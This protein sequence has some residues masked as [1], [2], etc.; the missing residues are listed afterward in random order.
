LSSDNRPIT[1]A[2]AVTRP[3]RT[4]AAPTSHGRTNAAN[5]TGSVFG[6]CSTVV[7]TAVMGFRRPRATASTMSVRVFIG[8]S[9]AELME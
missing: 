3:R 6:T 2:P 1:I 7:I 5:I 9:P 4:S 8:K